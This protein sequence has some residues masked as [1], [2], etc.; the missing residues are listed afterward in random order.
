MNR[1]ALLLALLIAPAMASADSLGRLFYTPAQ[2]TQLDDA[3]SHRST[4]VPDAAAEVPQ[5]QPALTYHGVVRRSDGKSTIWINNRPITDGQS[6]SG[7]A[8]LGRVRPDGALQLQLPE[9]KRA[10][11]LKVGQTLEVDTGSVAEN[12]ARQ[13]A[14]PQ[15]VPSTSGPPGRESTFSAMKRRLAT[16]RRDDA[17]AENTEYPG[18]RPAASVP[19]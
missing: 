6:L 2:R 15:P 7:V 13:E 17:G 10:V 4:A 12:Y 8:V 14:L 19:R 16:G 18:K 5:P 9:G 1:A 3:R 11:D